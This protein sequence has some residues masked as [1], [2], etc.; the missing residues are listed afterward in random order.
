MKLVLDFGLLVLIWLVQLI[1]YPSFQYIDRSQM[2]QWHSKYTMLITLVVMPLMLGQ[3]VAHGAGLFRKID[4]LAIVQAILIAAVWAVTFLKAVPLHN[5]IQQ[6]NNLQDNIQMLIQ[7]NWPRTFLWTTVFA[8][9][10]WESKEGFF[11]R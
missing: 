6:G 8:I 1:I 10:L 3:V 11:Q 7:W 9:S 2:A 5:Q 4:T